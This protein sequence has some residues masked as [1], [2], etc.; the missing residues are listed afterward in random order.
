[1]P[2]T[3]KKKATKKR[4]T[5]KKA[6][7]RAPRKRGLSSPESWPASKTETRSVADLVPYARNARMHSPAQV[8]KIAAS[9]REWGWTIPVLVDEDNGIIAGHGRILAA[10]RLKIA[11]V[12]VVIARGWS[13]EQKR[14]YVIA[15][16]KL[17]IN[18][19]WDMETLALELGELGDSFDLDLT[20]FSVGEIDS[21]LTVYDSETSQPVGAPHNEWRGM[22][23]F[24]HVDQ[25]SY[26]RIIIHF[27]C[28]EDIAEFAKRMD[29]KIGEKT[30]SMWFPPDD[31]GSIADKRYGEEQDQEE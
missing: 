16:N 19:E 21:L 18:S 17:T 23:E 20:G 7:K 31:I 4:A 8:E 11:E 24:E 6:A 2:R 28:E 9:I 3:T 5:K 22:P 26:R 29:Q 30:R 10:A 25:T 14:A 15:D 27:K 12:P 1:M 13:E